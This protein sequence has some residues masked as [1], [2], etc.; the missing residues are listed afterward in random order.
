MGFFSPRNSEPELDRPVLHLSGP[1][2]TAATER[3]AAACEETGGVEAY[4]EAMKL[5]AEAFRK[6]FDE[7]GPEGPSADEF[8]V[9]AGLMPTVRRRIADWLEGGN[10]DQLMKAVMELVSAKHV[11]EEVDQ[12]I[13]EF[14]LQ[15]PT[16]KKFRWAKDLAAELLHALDPERYPLMTRWVWDEG[17]NTGVLREIWHGDVDRA[18]IKV[19]DGYAMH[20]MLRE[21]L[22]QFLADN[23]VF[24]DTLQYVD[25]L[26]AQVYAEYIAAQGGSYLRADFTAPEDSVAY[27][28]RLLGLDGVRITHR[29]PAVAEAARAALPGF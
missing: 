18:M 8:T 7:A 3:L 24:R 10:F 6:I 25:L 12:R 13:A 11:P 9:L 15:F 22:S 23:G 20:V 21:E 17:A 2:L 26:L 4:V 27:L 5:K 29:D 16:G 14:C 19:G 28:R 1:A